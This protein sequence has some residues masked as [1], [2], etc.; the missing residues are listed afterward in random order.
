MELRRAMSKL[1]ALGVKAMTRPGLHGDG[2]GLY[3]QVKPPAAKSWL[4]RYKLG[5]RSRHMGLGSVADVSLAQ[6]RDLARDARRMARSGAD[7]ILHRK[8]ERAKVVAE[9]TLNTFQEVAQAYIREHEAG[10]RNIKHAQQWKNT[11][12]DYAYPVIGALPVAMIET[13]HI[14]K[15]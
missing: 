8:V 12:R 4:L 13:A 10:W 14:S 7:P 11:L 1:T 15:I 2:A 6:A 3:L 9:A 5:G